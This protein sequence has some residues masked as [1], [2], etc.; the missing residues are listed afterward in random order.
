[1]T[2]GAAVPFWYHRVVALNLR[3]DA[4]LDAALTALAA[5][6]GTS[7]HEVIR[8]AVFD[9]YQRAAHVASVSDSADRMMARWGD[10]ID[11]LG[12]V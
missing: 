7:K 9:R 12:T 2:R 4:E 5:A 10:V 8:R 11:R 3:V 6:E 1:M